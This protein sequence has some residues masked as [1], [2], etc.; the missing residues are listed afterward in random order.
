MTNMY[1]YALY[2]FYFF[3]IESMFSTDDKPSPASKSTCFGQTMFEFDG[4]TF[5][6]RSFPKAEMGGK[7]SRLEKN[8]TY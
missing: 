3:W 4:E 7:A 5:A 6:D 8:E 1:L 2:V